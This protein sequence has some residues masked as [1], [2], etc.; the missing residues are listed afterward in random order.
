MTELRRSNA[1]TDR[2]YIMPDGSAFWTPDGITRRWYDS[3]GAAQRAGAPKVLV[4]VHPP[5]PR[6]SP[7]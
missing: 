6:N 1:R 5:R 2:T 4:Y 3:A 7:G